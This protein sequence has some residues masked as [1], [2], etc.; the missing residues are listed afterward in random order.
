MGIFIWRRACLK[1]IKIYKYKTSKV[2]W[3]FCWLIFLPALSKD[4]K[5]QPSTLSQQCIMGWKWK[6]SATNLWCKM[7]KQFF[8]T[9][10][11][12]ILKWSISLHS[13]LKVEIF[14]IDIWKFKT[15]FQWSSLDAL[16]S[17]LIHKVNEV[18]LNLLKLLRVNCFVFVISAII[19]T[20]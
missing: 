3:K 7:N 8:L 12:R 17:E 11:K 15:I 1:I 19:L 6:H 9:L 5:V 13:D 2:Q 20:L 10:K 16:I 18:R 4:N 14:F